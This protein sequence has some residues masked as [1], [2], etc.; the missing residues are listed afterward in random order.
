MEDVVSYHAMQNRSATVASRLKLEDT[1]GLDGQIS[2]RTSRC[3]RSRMS[4]EAVPTQ[5]SNVPGST[6]KPFV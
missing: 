5:M 4:S 6:R 1:V 3:P 2:Y